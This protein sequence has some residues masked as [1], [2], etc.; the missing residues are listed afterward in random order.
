MDKESFYKKKSD[1]SIKEAG[2]LLEKMKIRR[3]KKKN[4]Q[5]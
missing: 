1:K 3:E 4:D 5:N 2:Q